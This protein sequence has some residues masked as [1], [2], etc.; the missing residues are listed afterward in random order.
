ME[1]G[2]AWINISDVLNLAGRTDEALE[3][4]L[5]GLETAY[6]ARLADDR[7]AAA[8]DLGVQV[9]PRR[10]GQARRR[11]SH[12]RAGGTPA[13]RCLYW[14]TCAGAARARA[15]R[16]RRRRGRDRDTGEG[17][18]RTSTEPQFVGMHGV[19]Q[20]GAVAPQRRH[21][22]RA[23]RDRRRARPD[24]VLLGGR[25]A[26][27]GARG[28]GSTGRGRRR[29]GRARPARRGGGAGGEDSCRRAARTLA[30]GGRGGSRGRGR[31]ARHLRGRVRTRDRRRRRRPLGDRGR[32]LGR[33][34]A[35]LYRRVRALARG[36]GTGWQAATARAHRGL[37][38]RRW[39]ARAE[40]GSAWLVEEVESLA[41]RARL[42]LGRG[43]RGVRPRPRARRA[44]TPS[45]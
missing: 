17:D 2:G 22:R 6:T 8:L 30:A 31:P 12:R 45:A 24:R 20:R 5:Q 26:R 39:P 9:P 41:A 28:D 35:P 19:L 1:E 3:V 15:R 42:Q 34:Q 36:R 11:R 33:A 4:A 38:R 21:R 13:A 32:A 25:G 18:A 37:R 27:G 44:T 10:L 43:R 29:R 40:L 7:L 14:Q 23:R 16:P